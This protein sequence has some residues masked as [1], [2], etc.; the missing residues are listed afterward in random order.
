MLS[1]QYIINELR[2]LMSGL[3]NG[4]PKDFCEAEKNTPCIIQN[5]P[6]LQT[7][8]GYPLQVMKLI[9][10]GLPVIRYPIRST[11]TLGTLGR[12]RKSLRLSFSGVI[13]WSRFTISSAE[14]HKKTL[15]YGATRSGITFPRAHFATTSTDRKVTASRQTSPCVLSVYLPDARRSF[16]TMR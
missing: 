6:F 1:S 15:L 8:V 16:E 3:H 2:N 5:L 10:V 12:R 14:Q 4:Y 9:Y 13:N 7:S 11:T